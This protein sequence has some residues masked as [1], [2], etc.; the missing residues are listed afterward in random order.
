M[1]TTHGTDYQPCAYVQGEQQAPHGIATAQMPDDI[2]AHGVDAV[3]TVVRLPRKRLQG[4]AGDKGG[5][6]TENAP[7]PL[8]HTPLTTPIQQIDNPGGYSTV[9]DACSVHDLICQAPFPGG[10]PGWVMLVLRHYVQNCK[11]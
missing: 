8:S 9:C 7:F 2:A 3:V 1:T 11:C 5:S 6:P 10:Q 4:G